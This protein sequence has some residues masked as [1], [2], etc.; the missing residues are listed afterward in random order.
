MQGQPVAYHRLLAAAAA[1]KAGRGGRTAASAPAGEKCWRKGAREAGQ[2]LQQQQQQQ[3]QEHMMWRKHDM[4]RI[5]THTCSCSAMSAPSPSSP[6]SLSAGDSSSSSASLASF[7]PTSC[8]GGRGGWEHCMGGGGI[9][10]RVVPRTTVPA[11]EAAPRC[12][13][14]RLAPALHCCPCCSWQRRRERAPIPASPPLG[15]TW[16]G[17]V[18]V[19]A[20]TALE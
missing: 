4:W 10:G 6:P 15:G 16:P 9:C 13:C 12:F 8:H 20:A 11:S 1:R 3:Q 18:C 7:P 5:Y 19:C 2:Q 17:C 14:P